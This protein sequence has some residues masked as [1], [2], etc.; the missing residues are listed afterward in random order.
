MKNKNLCKTLLLLPFLALA[1]CQSSTPLVQIFIY[2]STDTFI[3]SLRFAL[4]GNLSTYM[5]YDHHFAERKQTTQNE[6][7]IEALNDSRTKILVMNTVDRLASSALIEKA[8]K[9]NV[10]MIFFN[11][12]PLAGDFSGDWASQNCYYVGGDPAVE[13]KLQAEAA[14]QIIGGSANFKTSLYDK[15]HD[16]II[17]VTILK[18]EQGHQD[19]EQRSE[20]CISRLR[21]LGYTVNILSSVYCNWERSVAEEEMATLYSPSIELLFSNN[22]DMA[23]GA[24]DYL[25]KKDQSASSSSVASSSISSSSASGTTGSFAERYFPIIG[26]DDTAAGQA[27]IEEGTLTATVLNNAYKQAGVIF[28]LIQHALTGKDIPAYSASE[29]VPSGNFYHVLGQI[30]RK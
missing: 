9:K 18:G 26:V 12:E 28:D 10:P 16:G 30:V 20:Y 8:E 23:L 25:K 22:D 17:D 13:G 15:D 1:S 29:V 3:S 24:I 6:Q 2:D 4:E 27:A 5:A 7:T 21:E 19:T 11:R 14:D